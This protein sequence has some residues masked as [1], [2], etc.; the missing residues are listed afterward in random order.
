[1]NS[2][3]SSVDGWE[4]GSKRG[5]TPWRTT[6]TGKAA[7][8]A[9]DYNAVKKGVPRRPYDRFMTATKYAFRAIPVLAPELA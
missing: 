7:G 3:F 9:E 5:Q 4:P 8:V 1:M 6:S 2:H